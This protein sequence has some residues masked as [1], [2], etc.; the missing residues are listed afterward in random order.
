MT[1]DSGQKF[2]YLKNE[3]SFLQDI[4]SI[5]H[6]FQRPF[7]KPAK[8]NLEG[9]SPSLSIIIGLLGFQFSVFSESVM[10]NQRNTKK[11]VANIDP[12]H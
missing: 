8:K 11:R 1:K 4:N 10:K 5:F 12:K 3:K 9:E 2:R 6:H 7:I